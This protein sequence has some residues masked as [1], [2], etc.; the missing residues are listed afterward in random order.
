VLK[1]PEI[2]SAP[3]SP[4]AD[5][6]SALKGKRSIYFEEARAFTPTPIYDFDRL[7]PGTTLSGPAIIETPVTT[8][9][10]NPKDQAMVDEFH[11][12]RLFVGAQE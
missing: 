4:S 3:T 7:V 8:I 12:V 2:K 9:V 10:V 5:S 11:N 6:D 1:K